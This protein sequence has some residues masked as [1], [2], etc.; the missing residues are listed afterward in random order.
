VADIVSPG[1]T[2]SI[3]VVVVTH[4]SSAVLPGCLAAL[5]G[6]APRRGLEITVVDNGSA[7][8]SAALA[9]SAPGVGRVVRL[10]VNR[11]FA[12]GV[13]AGLREVRKPWL[14]AI[15]PD[16]ELPAGGLDRL[17]DLLEARPRVALIG[18]RVRLSDGGWEASV[19]WFPTLARE[20][21]HAWLLDRIAG[22]PGRRRTFPSTTTAVDW[23]SGCAWLLR[24]EA[25]RATGPFDEDYF[26]YVEDV[27]YCHR[28]RDVGWE[29]L[30]TPEVEVLHRRGQGS[31]DSALLPAEGGAAL[32]RYFDKYRPQEGAALRR[33]L[34]QGWRLRRAFHALRAR[35]GDRSAALLERRYGLALERLARA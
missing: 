31:L 16:V 3:A 23:V 20:R 29:V 21:A 1:S 27:D 34:T 30:A 4:D 17:A 28:L 32:V 19:G 24:A 8:G 22:L 14:A 10:A 26:M 12:S 5:G 33:V 2:A 18:P 25:F 11:G 35:F 13:N 15:N 7:D 9:A 6:A